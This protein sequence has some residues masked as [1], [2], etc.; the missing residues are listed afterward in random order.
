MIA[1]RHIQE[2]QRQVEADPQN[3]QLK[4]TLFRTL[5]RANIEPPQSLL[6]LLCPGSYNE[7]ARHKGGTGQWHI[8]R[9]WGRGT[10][11]KRPNE[12]TPIEERR[13]QPFFRAPCLTSKQFQPRRWDIKK[14][15]KT[16]L[17]ICQECL[18]STTMHFSK[19]RPITDEAKLSDWAKLKYGVRKVRYN[20]EKHNIGLWDKGVKFVFVRQ[21]KYWTTGVPL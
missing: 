5:R 1:D 6:L 9:E 19:G 3:N 16:P 4:V 20:P 14:A 17:D 12:K 10:R 7:F 18:K 13:D 8:I 15:F 11:R 2:L 21:S